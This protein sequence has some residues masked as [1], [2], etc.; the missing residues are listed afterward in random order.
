MRLLLLGY[1]GF[2][3]AGDEAILEAEVAAL[4]D[5]LG[6][7]TEFV[8]VSGDPAYTVSTHGLPA[9]SRTDATGVVRALRTCDALVAG[10]GSLLQDV[11]SA[12]PVPFYA[13]LML[14]A[15]ALRKPVFVYA[16]GL[17]PLHLPVN[18]L[19]TAAALKSATYVALR[20]HDSLILAE[21]L[22]VR[23]AELVADPVLGL[24]HSASGAD[25]SG[26][27]VSLRP[28]RGSATWLPVVR[29]ALA[30]LARDVDVALVPYHARQDVV[31]ARELSADLGGLRVVEPDQGGHRAAVDA[32]AGARAVLGMRLHALLVAAAAGRPFVALS[33]DPK[34]TA[35]A[36][37]VGQPVAATLPGPIDQAALVTSVRKALEDSPD[38]PYLDRVARLRAT[39]A[40]PADAIAAHLHR[41]STSTLRD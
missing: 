23:G 17:G 32:V 19:L 12:R 29:S 21:R 2:G 38:R 3:N 1:F 25:P 11:T 27:A 6:A 16:Q 15:R 41:P 8:V 5:A 40:R 18:R 14:M 22:G 34:V 31:L 20:D 4:R 37:Q 28:W 35:F 9:I 24:D 10:G 26:L 30:T 36:A 39:A 7:D 33:Y 13:G